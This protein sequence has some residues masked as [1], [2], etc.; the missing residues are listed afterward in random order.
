[1]FHTPSLPSF[2]R[3][4][5]RRERFKS[6][7]GRLRRARL[8]RLP[9][10]K[11]VAQPSLIWQRLA[12]EVPLA[13]C[14]SGK[15]DRYRWTVVHTRR[16]L[17]G[18]SRDVKFGPTSHAWSR[19][20]V[21]HAIKVESLVDHRSLAKGYAMRAKHRRGHELFGVILPGVL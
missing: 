14:Q 17:P 11:V 20:E 4:V 21:R 19:Q 5:N 1:M 9:G 2:V 3:H 6:G 8:L 12:E 15:G 10:F 7:V 18:T 13:P 16:V